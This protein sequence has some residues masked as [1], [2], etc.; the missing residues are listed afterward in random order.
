[1]NDPVAA[2]AEALDRAGAPYLREGAALR[3]PPETPGGFEVWI[4]PGDAWQVA[5]EG[6][7][8]D[9]ADPEQALACFLMGL[10]GGAR[11]RVTRRGGRAHKWQVETREGTP[12]GAV[13]RIAFAFWRRPEVVV[14]ENR[15]DAQ[16]LTSQSAAG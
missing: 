3:V 9:F 4:G 8:A 6:W 12:L 13:G 2:A 14:L 1:M 15:R 7:H 10:T 5:Y 11:L 16:S